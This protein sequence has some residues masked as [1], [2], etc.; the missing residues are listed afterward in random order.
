MNWDA[1][2]AIGELV[3]AAGVIA[4]LAY[5]AFQIRDNTRALS[6]QSRHSISEFVLQV[7]QFRTEHADR[8]ARIASAT[9]LT[10]GDLEFRYWSHMQLTLHAETYFH[11]VE[12]GLMPESHWEG[13]RRFLVGYLHSPGFLEFWDD[14]GPAFSRDFREWI[15]ARLI[16]EGLRTA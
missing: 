4:T 5:L 7:A 12:L 13:Y 11:H 1:L 9:E 10:P 8:Y 2:G 3:G 6:A 14:V 15:D 16:E